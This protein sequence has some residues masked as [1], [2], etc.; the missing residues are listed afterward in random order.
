[1]IEHV[2]THIIQYL[3]ILGSIFILTFIIELIRKKKLK[4]EY[5]LLWLFFAII[6]LI[7]SIWRNGLTL[8][9][10]LLGVAYA[11]SALFLILIISFF[12]ILLHYS[13]IISRL[14]DNNKNLI[15][16]VGILRM[17]LKEIKKDKDYN[18]NLYP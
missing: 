2:N 3:S 14:S 17:E 18:K 11:P 13:V 10:T 16:E 6:F 8:V 1:M 4:E 5:A 9:A 12:C 15:Q 7:F